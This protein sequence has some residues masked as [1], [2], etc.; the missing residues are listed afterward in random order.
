[1]KKIKVGQVLFTKDG[2]K[3]GNAVVQRIFH[4]TYRQQQGFESTLLLYEVR[5]DVGNTVN[6]TKQEIL[7]WFHL[8]RENGRAIYRRNKSA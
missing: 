1:M 4:R 3:I 6:F 7:D 2:R 5:T 8:T